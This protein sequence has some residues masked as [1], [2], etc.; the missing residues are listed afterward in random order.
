MR[1]FRWFGKILRQN[2]VLDQDG[3][4]KWGEVVNYVL[5]ID[6]IEYSRKLI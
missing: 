5:T 4:E 6:L 1:P 3:M 2:G